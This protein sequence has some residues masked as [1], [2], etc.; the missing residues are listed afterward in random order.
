MTRPVLAI[1]LVSA[2][3]TFRNGILAGVGTAGRQLED[4][5]ADATDRGEMN[6]LGKTAKNMRNVIPM[7][8]GYYLTLHLAQKE[9]RKVVLG[10]Q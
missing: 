6:R 2:R 3:S 8:Q 5:D 9:G 7:A 10:D 1:L 4:D